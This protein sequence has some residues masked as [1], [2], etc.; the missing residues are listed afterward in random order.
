MTEAQREAKCADLLRQYPHLTDHDAAINFALEQ[1]WSEPVAGLDFLE[2][3]RDGA[4]DEIEQA[5]PEYLERCKAG[6]GGK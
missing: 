1:A 4:W 3:W 5:F 2:T 6:E